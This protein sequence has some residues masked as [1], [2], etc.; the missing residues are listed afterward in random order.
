[1]VGFVVVFVTPYL[2]AEIG[3]GLGYIWG[4]FA[5]LVTIWAWF[6]M[7]ELKVDFPLPCFVSNI[8]T[9]PD[10]KQC[11][12]LEEIDQLF[13]A[14]LPAWKFHKFKTEG[15][16]HIVAEI[17]G[18]TMERKEVDLEQAD[19]IEMGDRKEKVEGERT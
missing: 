16:G 19:V 1:M 12:N 6:C 3:A 18:G 9:N 8:S 14:K 4:G 17:E 15:R 11:R 7:P 13:E 5:F 10:V 2:L